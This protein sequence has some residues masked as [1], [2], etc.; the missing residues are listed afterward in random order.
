MQRLAIDL[1]LKPDKQMQRHFWL[2][3]QEQIIYEVD[4]LIKVGFIRE[5]WYQIWLSNIVPVRKKNGKIKVC[6]DFRDL[7]KS[8]PKDDFLIPFTEMMIDYIIRHNDLS[9]MDG[10]S[11]YN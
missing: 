3:L 5:V 8:C 1:G 4:K 11:G 2:K 6:V 9:F 10:L 7:N